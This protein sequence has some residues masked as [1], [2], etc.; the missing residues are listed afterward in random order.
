MDVWPFTIFL[1]I[2]VQRDDACKHCPPGVPCDPL[3][4][5]CVKGKSIDV[6]LMTINCGMYPQDVK[7]EYTHYNIKQSLKMMK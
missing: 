1:R 4:G 2:S 7:Q 5:A 6:K 3:T